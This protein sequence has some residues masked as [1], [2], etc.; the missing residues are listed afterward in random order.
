MRGKLLI[1]GFLALFAA[2]NAYAQGSGGG[3]GGQ[4]PPPAAP[5]PSVKPIRVESRAAPVMSAIPPAITAENSWVLDLSDGGRV[6]IQLRPDH[7]P[8]HVER[9]KS[10]TRRGFYNGIAFHRVVDGFMAQGGDPTGTG[11]GDSGLPDLKAEFN[12]LPH[13][14]GAVAMARTAE[15]NS[16]NSQ[17]YIMFA[18]RLSM[19]RE[20][21]VFGRVIGGMEHVDKIQRGEPPATPTRIVRAS[22]G[23]DNAPRPTAEEIAAVV[24]AARPAPRSAPLQVMEVPSLTGTAV[25]AQPATPQPAPTATPATPQN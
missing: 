3:R 14:R 25:P 15:E 23:S 10:L 1:A 16:A 4:R 5:E 21:T 6:T 24:S 18:P 20:Y 11:I 22:I 13:L 8:A 7:A 9:I 19:D 17:F 2:Q 12:A